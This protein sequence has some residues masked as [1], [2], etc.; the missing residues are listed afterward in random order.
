MT[1]PARAAAAIDALTALAIERFSAE[2]PTIEAF[3]SELRRTAIEGS[4]D[5]LTALLL[6]FEDYLEALLIEPRALRR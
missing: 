6:R 5:E 2:R 4:L 1:T 3:A